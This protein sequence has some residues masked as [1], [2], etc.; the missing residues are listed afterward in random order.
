MRQD[1]PSD[2]DCADISA[3][4]LTTPGVSGR[5]VFFGCTDT[6]SR[7]AVVVATQED[8]AEQWRSTLEPGS[9]L[10]GVTDGVVE[11]FGLTVYALTTEL[12]GSRC[13]QTWVSE[14]DLETGAVL[15]RMPLTAPGFSEPCHAGVDLVLLEVPVSPG[16]ST[17][18][19]ELVAASYADPPG[20]DRT[21]LWR[22]DPIALQVESWG[23]VSP[24]ASA[25]PARG[26]YATALAVDP[27]ETNGG[28]IRRPGHVFLTTQIRRSG[29]ASDPTT[30]PWAYLYRLDDSLVAA[31][32]IESVPRA[33]ITSL[34]CD[35]GDVF[36]GG[37]SRER[38][39]PGRH[40][41]LPPQER[42]RDLQSTTLAARTRTS[43]PSQPPRRHGGRPTPGLPVE[44]G[45]R[46]PRREPVRHL[47]T[48]PTP[49]MTSD[50]PIPPR[51]VAARRRLAR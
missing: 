3:S 19:T 23:E 11:D 44:C 20:A 45:L 33:V 13:P 39:L 40:R 1:E 14:L 46:L 10:A 38:P 36:Y 37:L 4:E 49:N 28:T 17:T 16:S 42:G 2:L 47:L 6:R 7:T 34:W 15:R 41:T 22:I 51:T 29:P 50:L 24:P 21:F 35:Q 8:N 5:Y 9:V 31:H 48:W 27:Y 30:G 18:R 12:D 43:R 32:P 25:D 26:M